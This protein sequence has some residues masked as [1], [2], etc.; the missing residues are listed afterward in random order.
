MQISCQVVLCLLAVANWPFDDES[1]NSLTKNRYPMTY[2]SPYR[3]C[4]ISHCVSF[5]A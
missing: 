1:P 4:S 2:L 3:S 5:A